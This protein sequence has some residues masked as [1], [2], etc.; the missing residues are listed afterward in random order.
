M[1]ATIAMH[2]AIPSAIDDCRPR[3][4]S[5]DSDTVVLPAFDLAG[6]YTILKDRNRRTCYSLIEVSF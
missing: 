5:H 4:V 6:D 2:I 1:I 3:V